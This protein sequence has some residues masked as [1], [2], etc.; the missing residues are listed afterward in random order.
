MRCQDVKSALAA[1]RD[2]EL[3]QSD[4]LLLEEHLR[5]CQDCRTFHR[6]VQALEQWLR[7]T[8]P[9]VH[10]SLSTERIM[11]AVQQHKRITQQLENLRLQQRSRIAHLRIVGPPLIAA[12]VFMVS[13]VPVVVVTLA[14]LQPDLFVKTLS[15]L[16]DVVGTLIVFGQYL[17]AGLKLV[18]RNSWLLSVTAF[19]L[20]VMMGIWLRLMRYPQE[21]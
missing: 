9:D 13:S 5:Q 20:V 12:I 2:G 6:R 11:L 15:F 18:T 7:T 3:S 4:V 14:I 1:Q 19:I 10:S 21:A 8:A 17:Q 16:S